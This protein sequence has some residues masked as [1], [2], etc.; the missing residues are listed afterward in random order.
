MCAPNST[1]EFPWHCATVAPMQNRVCNQCNHEDLPPLQKLRACKLAS[2]RTLQTT[3]G[4]AACNGRH[5]FECDTCR[6]RK[7]THTPTHPHTRSPLP[8]LTHPPIPLSHSQTRP[9]THT[10][11]Y[12]PLICVGKFTHEALR[13]TSF[14]DEPTRRSISNG[15]TQ[16]DRR[17]PKVVMIRVVK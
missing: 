1:I 15:P 7:A 5:I 17:P 6:C 13:T 4:A 8:P 10:L 9:H 3:S 12:D 11:C 16:S 2:G 14:D